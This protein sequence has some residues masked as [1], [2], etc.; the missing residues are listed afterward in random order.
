MYISVRFFGG[1]S[2]YNHRCSTDLQKRKWAVANKRDKKIKEAFTT[3]KCCWW[4][5]TV[6]STDARLK[7]GPC[8]YLI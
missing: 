7:R 1:T 6:Y 8:G 5:F 4:V 2:D 3:D